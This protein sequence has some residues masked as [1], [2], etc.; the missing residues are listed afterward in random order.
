MCKID[1]NNNIIIIFNLHVN[2]STL[3]F[4]CNDLL[5]VRVVWRMQ[6][7]HNDNWSLGT[8][9]VYILDQ[10]HCNLLNH[11]W[12]LCIYP[13]TI[14]LDTIHFAASSV[15]L[16]FKGGSY[17]R[18]TPIQRRRLFGEIQYASLSHAWNM[19]H[20]KC[21]CVLKKNFYYILLMQER[22]FVFDT[23]P[24]VDVGGCGTFSH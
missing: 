2:T 6:L 9:I 15:Q 21:I 24:Q 16:L 4:T 20:T 23:E 12:T 17:S 10:Q 1:N 3:L 22:C 13:F 19:L 7:C 18:A 8:C 14:F 5:V 11:K